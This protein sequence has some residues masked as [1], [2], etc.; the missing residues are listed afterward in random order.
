MRAGPARNRIT[1]LN[2]GHM[3]PL[4]RRGAGGEIEVLG[5]DQAGPPLGCDAAIQYE[6]F[7]AE[8]RPGDALVMFTDG[9]SEA[10]NPNRN[11]YGNQRLLQ[12]VQVAPGELDQ[13]CQCALGRRRGGS[14][15]SIPKATISVWSGYSGSSRCLKIIG[16]KPWCLI[17]T[18]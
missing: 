4:C 18:V 8:L 6:P 16:S 1:L 11:L 15:R 7:T 12:A 5:G 10:M 3:P 17:W 2:A 9:I 14:R 13:L